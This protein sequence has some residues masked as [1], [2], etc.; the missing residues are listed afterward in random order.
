MCSSLSGDSFIDQVMVN[1]HTV[2]IVTKVSITLQ[3]FNNENRDS[4]LIVDNLINLYITL[5]NNFI[6]PNRNTWI[7]Q[8]VN[9]V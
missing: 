7:K 5:E 6:N 1:N 8:T 9:F 3:N 4:E 2:N